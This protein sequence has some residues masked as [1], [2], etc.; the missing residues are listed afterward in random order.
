[1]LLCDPVLWGQERVSDLKGF[2]NWVRISQ[3]TDRVRRR[4]GVRKR[5]VHFRNT[6]DILYGWSGGKPLGLKRQAK[7]RQERACKSC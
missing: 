5:I 3:V 6:E 4:F 1:M 2:A 7:V